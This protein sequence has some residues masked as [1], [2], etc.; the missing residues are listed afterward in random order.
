MELSPRAFE[1]ESRGLE[2]WYTMRHGSEVGLEWSNV[3]LLGIKMTFAPD[4]QWEHMH[5][6]PTQNTT[7]IYCYV[8]VSLEKPSKVV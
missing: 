1:R 2:V 6:P 5:K 7:L 3:L 8:D 4:N